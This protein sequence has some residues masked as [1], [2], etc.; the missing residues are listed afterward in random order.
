[1][2]TASFDQARVLRMMKSIVSNAD[3]ITRQGERSAEQSAMAM[4]VLYTAYAAQ[5]KPAGDARIQEGID[6]LFKNLENPS[7][8]NAFKF[9]ELLKALGGMLP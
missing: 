5:G 3:Y 9:G 6:G 7:A 4:R 2:T 1:M 8:Y